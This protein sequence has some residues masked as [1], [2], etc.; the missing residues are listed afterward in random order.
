MASHVS[1]HGWRTDRQI[2]WLDI[3]VA[4][5]HG[6]LLYK[7]RANVKPERWQYP[8]Q[9]DDFKEAL[10]EAITQRLKRAQDAILGREIQEGVEVL[11][12]PPPRVRRSTMA[13]TTA[14]RDKQRAVVKGHS[15]GR[16]GG[17]RSGPRRKQQVPVPRATRCGESKT[18][19]WHSWACRC[20]GL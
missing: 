11:L 8:P 15:R 18:G 7:L 16:E 12:A 1:W 14:S 17:R 13:S 9:P 20:R 3:A 19:S 6:E 10:R 4:G 2:Y 5:P